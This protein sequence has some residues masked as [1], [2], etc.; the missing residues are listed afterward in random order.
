MVIEVRKAK[1]EDAH[2]IVEMWKEFMKEHD[3]L[4]ASSNKE[5]KTHI[6]IKS[7]GYIAFS[8]Y[9]KK[10]LRSRNAFIQVAEKDGEMAGYAICLI[11]NNIPVFKIGKI[12]H[13]S[14]LYIRKKYRKKGISSK[15]R[16][17]AIS[18]FKKKG[19][20]YLAIGVNPENEYAHSI[21][22]KWG[23]IDYYIEMRKKI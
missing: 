4:V 2:K 17:D 10:N 15:F 23:F 20:Q 18:W 7:D 11:K 6:M 1:I 9:V 19:I 13:F 14:D 16:D 12:G 3:N 21:Y 8:S 5:L 22:K